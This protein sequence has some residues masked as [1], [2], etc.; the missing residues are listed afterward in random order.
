MPNF[1]YEAEA[2]LYAEAQGPEFMVVANNYWPKF[3][4][5]KT[6]A[7][8]DEVSYAFNGDSYP[9]GKIIKISNSLKRIETDT[10]VTFYRSGLSGVWLYEKT[11]SM[12]PGHKN[13]RNMSF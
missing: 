7:I 3:G 8:G 13:K 4:V 6:P 1:D 12:I 5:I 9:A 11:W 2:K 10:G